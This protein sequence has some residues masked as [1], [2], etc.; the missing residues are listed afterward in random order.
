M[1]EGYAKSQPMTPEQKLELGPVPEHFP[2]AWLGRDPEGDEVYAEHYKINDFQLYHDWPFRVEGAVFHN[3]K[4]CME[5]AWLLSKN[6]GYRDV[7]VQTP[8]GFPD[9][10]NWWSEER[11]QR[12]GEYSPETAE[13][14]KQMQWNRTHDDEDADIPTQAHLVDPPSRAESQGRKKAYYDFELKKTI[15]TDEY[16]DQADS[17]YRQKQKQIAERMGIVETPKPKNDPVSS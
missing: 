4:D 8:T 7:W 12:D 5:F 9:P 16:E 1:K 14:L 15:I 11:L 10:T 3:R 13:K 6:Q 2:N 17:P